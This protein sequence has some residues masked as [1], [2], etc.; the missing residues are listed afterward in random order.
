M[1]ASRMIRLPVLFLALA[2]PA[3]LS[4]CFLF[5]GDEEEEKK[6]ALTSPM[7]GGSAAEAT[8]VGQA[9]PSP[10]RSIELAEDQGS[11]SGGLLPIVALIVSVLSLGITLLHWILHR[12]RSR[13]VVGP[14]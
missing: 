1:R 8:A 12:R 7:E 4:G 14:P 10:W 6:G 2:L 3:T 13:M 11:S 5:G 9:P